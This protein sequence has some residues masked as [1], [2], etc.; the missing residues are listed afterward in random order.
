MKL[1][2][3]NYLAYSLGKC[4]VKLYIETGLI[5]ILKSTKPRR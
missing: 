2:W 4:A 1:M 5:K 3:L